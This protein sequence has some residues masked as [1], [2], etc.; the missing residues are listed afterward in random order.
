M[1]DYKVEIDGTE[2]TQNA[3]MPFK[4]EQLLD[5]QLDWASLT[6]VKV[7]KQ[8]FA[9]NTKVKIT[10]TSATEKAKENEQ[11]KILYYIVSTL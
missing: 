10:I 2:Y 9:P 4:F 11:E 6:L 8:C 1:V 7:G 3:V 5:E